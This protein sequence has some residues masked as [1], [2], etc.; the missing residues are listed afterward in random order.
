MI[1]STGHRISAEQAEEIATQ[2][3]VQMTSDPEQVG[4]FLATSGIG[5]KAIRTAAAE[6]GFLAGVL[7]F[8]M[9]DE[10]VL[11]AFC[12]NAGI[13]PTMIAAARHVL[14]KDLP[15]DA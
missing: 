12:E 3:L 11:L 7:E 5:P 10:A 9:S 6:P 1:D 13:R 14:A 2:A 4:R 8:Y 15:N